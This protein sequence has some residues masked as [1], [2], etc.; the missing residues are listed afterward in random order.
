MKSKIAENIL[1]LQQQSG[2]TKK[3]FAEKYGIK[4]STFSSYISGRATPPVELLIT[5]CN[6]EGV[7]MDWLCG[8][9]NEKSRVSAGQLGAMLIMLSTTYTFDT[10]ELKIICENN[11]SVEKAIISIEENITTTTDDILQMLKRIKEY[12]DVRENLNDEQ[13]KALEG[14]IIGDYSNIFIY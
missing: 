1:W 9:E 13:R 5:I 14:T 4:D 10:S 3:A 7:N 8:R 2:K 6:V 12:F 11:G